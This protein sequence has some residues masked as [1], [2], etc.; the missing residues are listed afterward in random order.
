[1]SKGVAII[2]IVVI[3][4][5]LNDIE[6]GEKM[7]FDNLRTFG[8]EIEFI[9]Q[10]N[11]QTTVREI[12]NYLESQNA[13]FDMYTAC[14]TDTDSSKWRLKTDASLY[15]NGLEIVSPVLQGDRG[16]RDLNIVL[17]ALDHIGATVN[18]SCGLHV[19][20]GVRDWN[21][22]NFRNLY[23]R[24]TK[25]ERAIDQVMPQSR[26]KDNN[27][28]CASTASRFGSTLHLAYKT[29]D[30]CR[31][32]R[33]LQEKIGTRYT[34]L[35]INSFWKHGTIEFRHHS[36]TTDVD[37]I[38]NWLKVCLSMC[39]AADVRRSIKVKR[40]DTMCQY[41]DKMGLMLNGLSKVQGTLI[42]SSVKRF[43]TKRRKQLCT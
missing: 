20:V 17:N 22:K 18:K 29:I 33:Q 9:A 19:H 42:D 32:A 27:Q 7:T 5:I 25:F 11:M 16:Y 24:W 30:K 34:K 13:T 38:T 2:T 35:N 28:Y 12:N 39:Q 8:I 14:Y 41:I 1:M 15:G 6:K 10:N 23:K 26:R 40:F 43:Y 3:I 37:K 31:T 4:N 21:I 36:G